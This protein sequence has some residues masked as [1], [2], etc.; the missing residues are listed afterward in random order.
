MTRKQLFALLATTIGSGIVILDGTVV[1]LALPS[2][3]RDL[4]ASFADL[5]W[6][7]DGY[8]LSLSALLLLG[9]SLG[10]I[11]GHRRVYQLGLSGFGIVS[12]LCGLAPNIGALIGLRILQGVFGALLVPGALAIINTNFPKNMRGTAIGR[13]SAWSALA[14]AIGPLLGGYIVDAASWRW[15]F[16]IN[17]P[18]VVVCFILARI[19]I[20]EKRDMT[21]RKV[22]IWGVA[23]AVLGL[24][25]VTYGLIEGP[26][27][28]WN[29]LALLPLIGG[30]VS[31]AIFLLV[32][33]RRKDP[34]VPLSLFGSRNFT[35]A[36]LATFTMYGALGG[37]LFSLVIF[38]Q[39][40][41]GYSAIK[42][43]AS[44]LPLTAL[45]LTLSGR[46]GGLAAKHGSRLFMTAGP[47]TCAVG[48]VLLH[49]LHHGSSY[50]SDIFP[51][52][53][54]FSLG[55]AITVAPLTTT[56]MRSVTETSSGIASAINN[57][58]S[59]VAS[60]IVVAVLGIL[61]A[62]HAYTFAI[63]LCAILAAAAGVSAWLL[64]RNDKEPEEV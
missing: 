54:L 10:D 12:L 15:I 1:N 38:L 11:F 2:I 33:R 9:G 34:M 3:A 43:G 57:A 23:F 8:A 36:N 49:G 13:W 55:L 19:G 22:D 35:G 45:L 62:A 21:P 59:R 17:V 63:T 60:L 64:V 14:A 51:G 27:R 37:F 26:T 40:T 42:A 5:Q 16:F 7:V 50:L 47:L 32:E 48:I 6:V 25:G 56:V 18:L 39:T 53:F 20:A 28:H 41:V 52:V 24:G 58:V 44:L 31:L 46:I 61:G 29:T 4:H 30:G